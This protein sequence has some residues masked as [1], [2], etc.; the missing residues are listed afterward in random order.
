MRKKLRAVMGLILSGA[1]VFAMVP[2][3]FAVGEDDNCVYTPVD[4]THHNVHYKADG[5]NTNMDS[6]AECVFGEDDTCICGNTKPAEEVGTQC[7]HTGVQKCVDNGNGTH[8]A[9]CPKCNGLMGENIPCVWNSEGYED[10]TCACGSTKP[11][12]VGTTYTPVDATHHHVHAVYEDG[13]VYDANVDCVFE[14]G[15]CI[16]GNVKPVE[17]VKPVKPSAADIGNGIGVV[18]IIGMILSWI[19][20]GF[21]AL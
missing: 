15:K 5:E 10:D 3:A 16:C 20:S 11:E 13:T 6:I 18:A 4:G 12:E 19:V 14:T 21:M 17:P 1:M 9:Y 7:D 2:A 8:N